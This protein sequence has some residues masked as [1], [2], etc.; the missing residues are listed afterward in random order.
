MVKMKWNKSILHVIGISMSTLVLAFAITWGLSKVKLLAPITDSVLDFE[1]TDRIFKE[2]DY[3]RIAMDTNIF[4]VN[5]SHYSRYQLAQ[6]IDSINNY[7]PKVICMDVLFRYKKQQFVDS[8]LE[9]SFSKVKNLLFV[10]GIIGDQLITSHDSF[11]NKGV[12]RSG[13][14]IIGLK[15]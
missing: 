2:K 9:S 6:I 13:N 11:T 10:G 8:I 3:T 15:D 4:I 1:F 7:N 5:V 14:L 12:I